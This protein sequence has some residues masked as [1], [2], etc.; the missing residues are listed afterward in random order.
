M[1]R[2]AAFMPI[3]DFAIAAGVKKLVLFHHDPTHSDEMLDRLFDELE[4]SRE[5]PFE[6]VRAVEGGV[7]RLGSG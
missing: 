5:L 1:T 7:F 6:L 2:M 4:K 3:V